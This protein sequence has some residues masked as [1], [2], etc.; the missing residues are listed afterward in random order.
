MESFIQKQQGRK[1]EFDRVK[2]KTKR[3]R[4]E[5]ILL[6]GCLTY[7]KLRGCL[8]FRNNSGIIFLPR[9]NENSKRAIRIGMQG[10]SDIVGCFPDGRFLAVECKSRKGRITNC[11]K[12][13]LDAVRARGGIALVVRS[14]DE[15]HSFIEQEL[16][17]LKHR[18]KKEKEDDKFKAIAVK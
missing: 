14:V 1:R 7:L 9:D 13:F 6:Q 16:K 4:E 15:L 17:A 5:Q 8:V 10:A 3:K 2:S 12:E 11:Q 18:K